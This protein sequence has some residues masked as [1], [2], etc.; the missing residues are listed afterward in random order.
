MAANVGL[1]K[2]KLLRTEA[3]LSEC[4]GENSISPT[5]SECPSLIEDELHPGGGCCENLNLGLLGQLHFKESRFLHRGAC[6]QLKV[7]KVIGRHIR[8]LVSN[9]D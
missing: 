5:E 3:L 6:H 9:H 8:N 2:G 7:Q 4:V 1:R